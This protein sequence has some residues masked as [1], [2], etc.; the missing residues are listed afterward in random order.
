[1]HYNDF[2][3]T[4]SF[5]EKVNLLLGNL[6]FTNNITKNSDLISFQIKNMT[7]LVSD[8]IKNLGS[9]FDFN[10][11]GE[12]I[13]YELGNNQKDVINL[14]LRF[15]DNNDVN[16]VFTKKLLLDLNK[17]FFFVV[18]TE[19]VKDYYNKINKNLFFVENNIKEFKNYN[20]V[21]TASTSK[22]AVSKINDGAII[23][24]TND[25]VRKE[26]LEEVELYTTEYNKYRKNEI[27][28]DDLEF[29]INEHKELLLDETLVT[30]RV[31]KL[32]KLDS[33][34][35]TTKLSSQVYD[36]DFYNRLLEQAAKTT[37]ILLKH[38]D[39]KFLDKNT[40]VC[41]VGFEERENLGNLNIIY[42]FKTKSYEGF[43]DSNYFDAIK[44]INENI[45][46]FLIKTSLV[47]NN[48][49]NDILSLLIDLKTLNKKIILVVDGPRLESINL[50]L[51]DTIIYRPYVNKY[52]NECLG[53]LLTGIVPFLG[54]LNNSVSKLL[55]IGYAKTFTKFDYENETFNHNVVTFVLKN[56][57][58]YDGSRLSFLKSNGRIIELAKTVVNK[59]KSEKVYLSFDDEKSINDKN[60][61]V[62]NDLNTIIF[63][64]NLKTEAINNDNRNILLEE[65]YRD[66]KK[67]KKTKVKKLVVF[68][69]LIMFLIIP[70][71]VY[72]IYYISDY[73]F[74]KIAVNIITAIASILAVA[75]EVYLII[76]FIKKDKTKAVEVDVEQ[77]FKECVNAT[78]ID[79]TN[80]IE[81]VEKIEEEVIEETKNEPKEVKSVSF[82]Y[83]DTKNND[84]SSVNFEK[85]VNNFLEFSK[86]NEVILDRS[87]AISLIS[88]IS[89]SRL[90]F[91]NGNKEEVNIFVKLV[92]SFFDNE[93]TFTSLENVSNPYELYNDN[94]EL[95]GL[96]ESL[97]SAD[98]NKKKI[99][100][101]YIESL[102]INNV[103]IFRK[104][105]EDIPLQKLKTN[106]F[107]SDEKKITIPKNLFY[108]VYSEDYNNLDLTMNSITINVKLTSANNNFLSSDMPL[109]YDDLL[110]E[111]R[112][113]KEDI[114]LKEKTWQKLDKF[115]NKLEEVSGF[116]INNKVIQGMEN[117]CAAFLDLNDDEIECI[118]I[119]LESKFIPIINSLDLSLENKKDL[120]DSLNVSF[121]ENSL[122]RTIKSLSE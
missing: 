92:M 76:S 77:I 48:L 65:F 110:V 41:A 81:P 97:L 111:V 74:I 70:F 87:L 94:G 90:I 5:K 105:L 9:S 6:D 40:H 1:M 27:T 29:Y 8:N 59:N 115:L 119:L 98:S 91:L 20:V 16:S 117:Y 38:D 51:V 32:F 64:N 58:N 120:I 28:K 101:T 55:P 66:T 39:D 54:F 96:S 112:L 113:T 52:S 116:V 85:F 107:L 31:K 67:F 53:Y 88:A 19:V 95:T 43:T 14:D 45:E 13:R 72:L 114:S 12:F 80:Y 99:Y 17:N 36:D 21:S 46:Y 93:Y 30:E 68:S 118:D 109:S 10:L 47:D 22:E 84:T 102:N 23:V 103:D 34:L 108:F 3:K 73:F 60:F 25:D 56:S 78:I 106:I 104:H 35:R 42:R 61:A 57:S 62:L 50:E 11:I 2:I 18:K 33:I 89:S 24:Y 49:D 82:I 37:P 121:G 79:S 69:Y 4:L 75:G 86:K 7:D 71:L 63:E 83:E 122:I 100:I 26:I 44:N 15:S